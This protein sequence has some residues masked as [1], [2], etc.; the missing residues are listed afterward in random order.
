[1]WYFAD[2]NTYG[3]KLMAGVY[4]RAACVV[5]VKGQMTLIG[6]KDAGD[7]IFHGNTWIAGGVGWC[8]TGRWSSPRRALRDDWCM[9]CVVNFDLLYRN[10][11]S[12]EYE[13]D[14]G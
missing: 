8:E 13:V 7:Y 14:C 10:G 2:R 4:G 11:W 12:M 5:N 9:A 1:M 6:T 3:G